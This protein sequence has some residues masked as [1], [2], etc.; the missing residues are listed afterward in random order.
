M[1][2]HK[3]RYLD[4]TADVFVEAYGG[5]LEAAFENAALAMFEIMTDTEMVASEAEERLEVE[6]R[7]ESALLYNWLEALLVRFE[8][9]NMLYSNFKIT[10]ISKTPRGFRLRATVQGEKLDPHRHSKKTG[11]KAITY[12]E[13]EIQRHLK[14]VKVKFLLDI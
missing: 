6:G 9:S 7:D 12:H 11:V 3:F 2:D 10:Q 5:S 13:M 4:H 1:K 8:V 14:E